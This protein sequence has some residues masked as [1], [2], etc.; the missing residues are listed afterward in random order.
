MT[1]TTRV[2]TIIKS[3]KGRLSRPNE[4]FL[5]RL[6]FAFCDQ[7]AL[8]LPGKIQSVSAI[9]LQLISLPA[10]TSV[11]LRHGQETCN[12]NTTTWF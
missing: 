12:S 4:L 7:R 10:L 6:H 8:C 3:L 9:T 5:E 2:A 1:L 11:F